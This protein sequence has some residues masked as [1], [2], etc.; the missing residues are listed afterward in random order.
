MD[1]GE[2]RVLPDAAG[3]AAAAD[4]ARARF[5]QA[6]TEDPA[7]VA[8]G[9]ALVANDLPAADARLLAHLATHPT[10]VAAL[11]MRAEIAG[12]LRRYG[13]AQRLLERCLELAPGFDVARHNYAVVLNR[14]GKAAQALPEVEK[15]LAREPRNPGYRNLKAGK[16][17][18]T[19]VKQGDA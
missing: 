15:L 11:R 8:A 3:D 9:A 17:G 16:G 14:Q 6:A 2:A 10:D 1:R 18:K 4:A 12:R 13:E 19:A 7:L 5:L